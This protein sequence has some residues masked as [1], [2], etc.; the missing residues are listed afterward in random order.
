MPLC[1]PTIIYKVSVERCVRETAIRN[2]L[3]EALPNTV[4]IAPN[5]TSSD[6]LIS[7]RWGVREVN[8]C[9]HFSPLII[10]AS[11]YYA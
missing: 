11:G 6:I 9:R 4:K 1:A 10:P 2:G 3:W 5:H 7:R 8:W